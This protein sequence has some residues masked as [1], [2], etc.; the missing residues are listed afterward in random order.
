M[1]YNVWAAL[2]FHVACHVP[3]LWMPSLRLASALLGIM[4]CACIGVRDCLNFCG[5][6][7][8]F[9]VMHEVFRQCAEKMHGGSLPLWRI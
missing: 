9:F 8:V 1:M 4:L 6:F 7:E 3:T 2:C 5:V